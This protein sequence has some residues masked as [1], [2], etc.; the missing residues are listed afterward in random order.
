MD[1]FNS[2]LDRAVRSSLTESKLELLLE[3]VEDAP[4]V[5][6]YDP[7]DFD[8]DEMT[9]EEENTAVDEMEEIIGHPLVG[10]VQ[11]GGS[12]EVNADNVE[13]TMELLEEAQER[14]DKVITMMEPGSPADL[15]TDGEFDFDLLTAPD[16]INKPYVWNTDDPAW[17]DGKHS[18]AQALLNDLTEDKGRT[19]LMMKVASDLEERIPDSLHEVIEPYE[20]AQNYVEN[21]ESPESYIQTGFDNRII[22]ETYLVVNPEAAVAEKTGADEWLRELGVET[23]GDASEYTGELADEAAALAGDKSQ[24]GYDGIIYVEASGSLGPEEIVTAAE[25]RCNHGLN[26]NQEVLVAYGGGIYDSEDM[27]TYLEAGADFVFVGNSVQ[28]QGAEALPEPG[29]LEDVI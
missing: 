23:S 29:E 12:Y 6:K 18:E 7:E 10:A 27:K 26:P 2:V 25:E 21:L 20:T 17:K 28:E 14:Q 19:A 22:P 1:L 4:I 5:P 13:K 11:V 8:P 3:E 16:I 24:D 9:V 15:Q